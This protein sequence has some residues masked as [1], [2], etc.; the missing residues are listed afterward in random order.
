MSTSTHSSAPRPGGPPGP[1]V[2]AMRRRRNLTQD[3]LARAVGCS[4]QTVLDLEQGN[5]AWSR[6]LPAI[7]DALEVSFAWLN[8]GR[9]PRDAGGVYQGAVPVVQWRCLAQAVLAGDPVPATAWLDGCP[10]R[11]SGDVVMAVADDATAFA[12]SPA[13]AAGD[14]LFIDRGVGVE[15]SAS[16]LVVVTMPGWAR[17][18]LRMLAVSGGQHFLQRTN[19]LLPTEAL[20]V[21]A[22]CD[23]VAYLAA[24]EAHDAHD[25]AERPP[26]LL[27]GQ[28]IFRG[29]P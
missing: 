9:G 19:P 13:I 21:R 11:H 18:E 20:S 14:W 26:A 2:R 12:M 16:G 25:A 22:Y 15:D 29:R 28:V 4:S 3:D 23:R 8:T 5:I 24:A 6:F 17:A 1:R 7:A 10:V 27:L